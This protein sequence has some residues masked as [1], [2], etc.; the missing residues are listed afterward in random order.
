VGREQGR[1]IPAHEPRAAVV[2]DYDIE[3][4]QRLALERLDTIP[5]RFISEQSGD[6][7]GYSRVLQATI[8]S[9]SAGLLF[10]A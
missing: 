2:H 3:I 1:V 7:N 9:D 6:Y 10:A 5:E 4:A 8:L